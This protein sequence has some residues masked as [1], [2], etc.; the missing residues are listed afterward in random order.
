[1]PIISTLAAVALAAGMTQNPPPIWLEGRT[2]QGC[3][4]LLAG[5]DHGQA[6]AAPPD[7]TWSGSCQ[8]G[9]PISGTGV[10][11]SRSIYE[12]DVT[13]ERQTGTMVDGYWHGLVR[14]ERFTSENGGPLEQSSYSWDGWMPTVESSYDM[15]CG[16]YQQ[17]RRECPARPNQAAASEPQGQ[18]IYD[19]AEEYA[20]SQQRARSGGA[21][22]TGGLD[23]S[24]NAENDAVDCLELVALNDAGSLHNTCAFTVEAVWCVEGHDCRPSYSNMWSIG[25]DRMYPVNGTRGGGYVHWG[26]CRGANSVLMGPD[27]AVFSYRCPD[28]LQNR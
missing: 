27:D 7:F 20:A 25:P 9:R 4:F 26:A 23:N 11:E 13:V 3:F 5:Y 17:E 16:E 12:G 8:P 24:H 28:R 21:G 14:S 2:T 18:R 6:S 22:G 1:M 10:L 15:G 19:T